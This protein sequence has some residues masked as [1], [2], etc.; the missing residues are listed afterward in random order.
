MATPYA[1]VTLGTV[2]TTQDEARIRIATGAGP[3]LVIAESQRAG[4]GRSGRPW[5]QA[6]RALCSSLAFRPSWP[7]ETWPRLTLVAGLAVRRALARHTDVEPGLKWPN[8]LMTEQGKL[9]GILTETAP[10]PD[11]PVPDGPVPDGP[12]PDGPFPASPVPHNSVPEG[13]RPAVDIVI[14]GCGVNLW[15]PDPDR[16]AG[17]AAAC[18]DDPGVD[19][20]VTIAQAWAA[21]VLRVGAGGPDGWD[22][23]AYREA[24]L[25]LGEEIAWE[26]EGRGTAVDVDGDGGLVVTT[27]SGRVTLVAGEVRSVRRR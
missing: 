2:D 13:D 18:D 22:R 24:C 17:I 3:V 20:A 9:G 6:P 16:P 21:E 27:A 14:I 11:G 8:D 15:W 23:T 25:T 26:P 5:E 12:V 4:R 19:L 1:T 10:G 7:R